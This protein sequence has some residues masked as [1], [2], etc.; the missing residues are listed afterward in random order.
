MKPSLQRLMFPITHGKPRD[1]ILQAC[2]LVALVTLGVLVVQQ[3][4][5]RYDE[6]GI[7]FSFDFLAQPAGYDI[8]DSLIEYKAWDPHWRALSAGAL[9]SLELACLVILVSTIFGAIAALARLSRH[10]V[11]SACARLY[12]SVARNVPLFIQL[13]L[14][15]SFWLIILRVLPLSPK[16][17]DLGFGVFVTYRGLHVPWIDNLLPL[18]LVFLVVAAVSAVIRQKARRHRPDR[19]DGILAWTFWILPLSAVGAVV[20]LFDMAPVLEVPVLEG[21]TLVGGTTFSSEALMAVFAFSSYAGGQL[22]D[23][24]YCHA[25]ALR[26]KQS[27][28]ARSL[29][30]R[31]ALWSF[32]AAFPS[33]VRSVALPTVNSYHTIFKNTALAAAI[34]YSAFHDTI[35]A[36]SNQTGRIF[37]A[38]LIMAAFYLP[39]GALVYFLMNLYRSRMA[40]IGQPASILLMPPLHE[41]LVRVKANGI[42]GW[43][44]ENLFYDRLSIVATFLFMLIFIYL[45]EVVWNWVSFVGQGLATRFECQATDE[46][47]GLHIA[48][49]LGLPGRLQELFIG[50]YSGEHAWRAY[51]V[52]SIFLGTVLIV[53]FARVPVRRMLWFIFLCAVAIWI[54]SLGRYSGS[55]TMELNQIGGLWL[56]LAVASLSI[57][58]GFVIGAG[59][60]LGSVS[61]LPLPQWVCRAIIGSTNAIPPINMIRLLPWVVSVYLIPSALKTELLHL[62]VGTAG[63]VAVSAAQFAAVIREALQRGPLSGNSSFALKSSVPDLTRTVV[64]QLH[65][66]TFYVGFVAYFDF[67]RVITSMGNRQEW[68]GLYSYLILFAAVVYYLISNL[69]LF[70]G[71]RL[72]RRLNPSECVTA[73]Q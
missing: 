51:L 63:L 34:G 65:Y 69:I 24:F 18:L 20:L 3:I 49:Q 28:G 41:D 55:P 37:E 10:R 68:L 11:L 4:Q 7:D 54:V 38:T 47:C 23:M 50:P 6:I 44:R 64:C 43:L 26:A 13:M 27:E 58:A 1:L 70:A 39:V 32:P 5:H 60:A 35:N 2:L 21:R 59:L 33:F 30:L 31:S 46:F 52:L 67:L 12:C 56:T 17:G 19:F 71:R 72:D 48:R 9:K 14:Q 29:G 8:P 22:G 42:L 66:T 15:L 61:R 16:Q 40:V 36:T 57:V 53:A 25:R 45:A 73:R 62:Y